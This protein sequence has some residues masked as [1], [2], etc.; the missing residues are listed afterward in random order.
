MRAILL[1]ANLGILAL[2]FHLGSLTGLLIAA[3]VC[4]ALV[5]GFFVFSTARNESL[6]SKEMRRTMGRSTTFLGGLGDTRR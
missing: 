5:A 1:L 2:A 3:A 6:E 4:I